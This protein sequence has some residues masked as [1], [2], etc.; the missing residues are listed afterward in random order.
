MPKVKDNLRI[1]IVSVVTA[2]AC[3]FGYMMF[4]NLCAELFIRWGLETR[5]T[6]DLFAHEF[7][8]T[9]LVTAL[10]VPVL[11]ELI[12]RLCSCKLLQLTKLPDWAVI[13]ISAVIFA[14]YHLSW[15]QLVYQFI[16][17]V[18]L[19]WIFIKTRQIGWTMLIHVIN[20]AIIVTYTYF[21]GEG[22]SVFTLSAGTVILSIGLA[23]ATTVAVF[24]L[25][26]KGI[27]NYEK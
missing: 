19:A 16:M 9:F 13:V 8:L 18:W 15:S 5:K 12:F 10:L 14:V 23:V 6:M 21:V 26:K 25:I 1:A 7:W 2:L 27:P 20:N 17:G 11:E 3:L 22:D 24:W 4:Q